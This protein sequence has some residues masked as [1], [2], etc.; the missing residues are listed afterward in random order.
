ML[1]KYCYFRVYENLYLQRKSKC[2]DEKAVSD[3]KRIIETGKSKGKGF[4]LSTACS[5]AP[6][7]TK[8]RL[9]MLS[10]LIDEYGQYNQ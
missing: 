4:I 9:L 6:M 1:I 2:R 5:I 3:V 8:E 7:V 10:Q